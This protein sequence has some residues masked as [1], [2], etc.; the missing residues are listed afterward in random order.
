MDPIVCSGT[1]WRG[2]LDPKARA[3]SHQGIAVQSIQGYDHGQISHVFVR[4]Q[5]IPCILFDDDGVV[6]TQAGNVFCV[7]LA[8]RS[9]QALECCIAAVAVLLDK[10]FGHI[11]HAF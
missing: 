2:S 9:S 6:P 1:F 11:R 7:G 8:Q 4:R 5:L 3:L 10:L